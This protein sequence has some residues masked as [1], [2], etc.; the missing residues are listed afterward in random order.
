MCKIIQNNLF[1]STSEN[2]IFFIPPYYID[3]ESNVES[4]SASLKH[5]SASIANEVGI[6]CNVVKS[7]Y[8]ESSSKYK[9]MRV[10]FISKEL[11]DDELPKGTH[12]LGSDWTMYKWITN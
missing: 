10:F 7:R 1:Y 5:Y 8:I 3:N 2:I 12:V 6:D 4:F 9:Q 11:S